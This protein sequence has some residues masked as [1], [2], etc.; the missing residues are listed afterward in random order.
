MNPASLLTRATVKVLL[1]Q[2]LPYRLISIAAKVSLGFIAK[3]HK[4]LTAKQGGSGPRRTAKKR[5][6][7]R[8]LNGRDQRSLVRA[9][10]RLR[11]RNLGFTAKQLGQEAGQLTEYP[12]LPTFIVIIYEKRTMF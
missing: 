5:V 4:E 7:P 9:V 2:G 1:R 6:R 12:L 3:C 11:Q 10:L 8:K